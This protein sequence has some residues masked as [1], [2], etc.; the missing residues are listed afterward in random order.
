[1]KFSFHNVRSVNEHLKRLDDYIAL[2]A[3]VEFRRKDG[4]K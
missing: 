2:Q 3:V 4:S 1:M